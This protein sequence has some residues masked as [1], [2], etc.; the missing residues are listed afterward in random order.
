MR[1]PRKGIPNSVKT[2]NRYYKTAGNDETI[3][4]CGYFLLHF[5]KKALDMRLVR[6]YNI[7]RGEWM[8]P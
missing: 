7:T 3:V 4:P 2:T 1:K 5:P 6:C 8:H